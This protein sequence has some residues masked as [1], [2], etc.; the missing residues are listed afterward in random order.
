M[1]D[2]HCHH[3]HHGHWSCA[4]W[5]ANRDGFF[6]IPGST[7]CMEKLFNQPKESEKSTGQK[8]VYPIY[9]I[10]SHLFFKSMWE[11]LEKI[12]PQKEKTDPED[13]RVAPSRL[14][15]RGWTIWSPRWRQ[16]R[17][18]LWADVTTW[19]RGKRTDR[20]GVRRDQQW[21]RPWRPVT[22]L[23]TNIAMENGHF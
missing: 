6:R 13:F 21:F 2:H 19:N 3:G 10:I 20:H 17:G 18:L 22:L 16:G 14:Q 9:S 15:L 8:D 5:T 4:S 23:W 7:R 12:S 1:V 11:S